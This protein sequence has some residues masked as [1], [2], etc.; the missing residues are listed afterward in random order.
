MQ[1]VSSAAHGLIPAYHEAPILFLRY[2]ELA[3]FSG[4]TCPDRER[5][6]VMDAVLER[7][8]KRF[9][10]I[11][12]AIPDDYLHVVIAAQ[13]ITLTRVGHDQLIYPVSTSALGPGNTEGSNKTPT[14]IHRIVETI[15]GDAPIYMEFKSRAPTG[16]IIKPSRAGVSRILSRILR[17]A[18]MEPRINKGGSV[19][20]FKRCIY[21]HGTNKEY[22]IGRPKSHGCVRMN[23]ADIIA[24][25]DMVEE[26]MIV[27]ID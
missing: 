3:L 18:G 9:D 21:I 12:R 27:V 14:G 20:T 17:L 8:A 1:P 25:F 23:N 11:A 4:D 16:R 19:D 2:D 13:T 6:T 26:G 15:G 22:Q 7:Y 5:E 10:K 24:L